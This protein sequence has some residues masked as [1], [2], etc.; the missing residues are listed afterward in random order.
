MSTL[1]PALLAGGAVAVL[2]S[3]GPGARRVRVVVHPAGT[4]RR[5]LSVPGLSLTGQAPTGRA[6]TGGA[7]AGQALAGSPEGMSPAGMWPA[8]RWPARVL[9]LAPGVAAPLL[10]AA[11]ALVA[12]AGPVVAALAAA[13][14]GAVT[15]WWSGRIASAQREQ[16]RTRAVEACGALAAELRAGRSPAQALA[17]AAARG[18]GA[19]GRALASAAAA[20]ELGGDVAA[21]LLSACGRPAHDGAG[22]QRRTKIRGTENRAAGSRTFSTRALDSS[23]HVA[24]TAVAPV[25]RA[26]A[27]CWTVCAGTGSGLAAAVE[28]LE[29]G[30]RADA[31]QRR[32]LQAE[33]AGPRATAGMLAALP[34]AGLLLAAGLGA[35]P[36]HVLL[37]TPVGLVCLVAGLGLDAVGL[38]WTGRLVARAGGTS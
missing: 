7:L 29:E 17:V 27:A 34:L 9:G 6:P 38:L 12:G 32:A 3:P 33:L 2:L 15:R 26:L 1:L 19:S 4:A 24:P 14:T 35:D 30:L 28:R 18:T 23:G 10:A 8:G 11:A 16:E 5:G 31:G 21:A 20:A 22:E 36:L 13:G 25:L 37:E